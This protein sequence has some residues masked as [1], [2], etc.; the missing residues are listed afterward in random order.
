M[1]ATRRRAVLYL[2]LSATVDNSTSLVRQEADLRAYAEAQ[3]LEVVAV[4]VDEDISGRKP[5]ANAERAIKMLADNEADVLAV[6]RLDRFTRQGWTGLGDLSLALDSR[7]YTAQLGTTTRAKFVALHDGLDSDQQAFRIIAGVL[8]EVAKTEA[9]SAA[10]RVKSSI[11]H[12]KLVTRRYTGGSAVP[13]GY[14]SVPAPDGTGRVLEIDPDEAA[15][16]REVAERLLSR[17]ESLLAIAKD[18]NA[19]EIPTSKS[20]ART[21][22]RQGKDM[23]GL[24]R[25]TWRAATLR[26]IWTSDTLAGRVVHHGDFVRDEDGL[27]LRVWPAVLDVATIHAIRERLN[28]TPPKAAWA[29][30]N[31]SPPTNPKPRVRRAARLLS[32]VAFCALCG[33]K[34][35]VTTASGRAVYACARKRNEGCRGPRISADRLD[36]YVAGEFLRI[37]G[38]FPEVVEVTDST[39]TATEAQLAE[40]E[41]ALREA[42]AALTADGADVTALVARIATLKEHRAE[43]RAAP[44]V[45]ETRL[46]PTGRTYEEAWRASENV[47][48][49]RNLLLLGVDHIEIAMG[50]VNRFEPGRVKFHWRS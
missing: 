29:R 9:D 50:T 4:L 15:I 32:G 40:V 6:W 24:E 46:E 23:A 44:T 25:G 2:R 5:R 10:L 11:R 16:V 49:R 36:E 21:A 27:P 3:D 19:R 28:W 45:E 12:R 39:A 8:S 7:A 17:T 48:W 1:T 43:L 31:Y 42:S 41:T 33:A 34:M 22:R 37:L 30:L 14:R 18:L 13:F 38:K 35:N 26:N 47:M 20:A